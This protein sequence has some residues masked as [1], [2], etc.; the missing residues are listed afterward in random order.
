M[1]ERGLLSVIA[2][3]VASGWT[4]VTTFTTADIPSHD[5]SIAMLMANPRRLGNL[6]YAGKPPVPFCRFSC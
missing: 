4:S 1:R 3:E 5:S 6:D 2:S